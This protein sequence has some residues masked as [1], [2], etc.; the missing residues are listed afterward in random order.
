VS[1]GA[2]ISLNLSKRVLYWLT[3]SKR[4]RVQVRAL[5]VV[6][7]ELHLVWPSAFSP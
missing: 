4:E 2:M 6:S 3:L 7:L 1:L 5:V